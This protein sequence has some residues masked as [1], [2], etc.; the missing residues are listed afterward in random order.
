MD[1]KLKMWVDEK[2]DQQEA[3]IKAARMP[4]SSEDAQTLWEFLK[5]SQSLPED[6]PLLMP[7]PESP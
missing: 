4:E 6:S 1:K 5:F 2:A 7:K 3:A